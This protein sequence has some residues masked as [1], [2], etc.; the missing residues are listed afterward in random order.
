[1]SKYCDPQAESTILHWDGLPSLQKQKEHQRRQDRQV[2]DMDV[3]RSTTTQARIVGGSRRK[4]A[5]KKAK[6]V[7]RP[8][9]GVIGEIIAELILT[10]GCNVC[11]CSYQADTCIA[12][13]CA[14]AVHPEDLFVVSGDS[15]MIA[16]KSIPRLIYPLGKHREMTVIEKADLLRVLELPSDNHLLLAAI[17]A[18]NDYTSGMPYY[19]LSRSCDIIRS[20]DLPLNDIESFRQYVQEYLVRVQREIF[21]RKRTRKNRRRMET[22]LA[23]GVEDF[24]HALR[25]F[26]EMT[27]DP[28]PNSDQ[29]PNG[30]PDMATSQMDLDL[31]LSKAL[32]DMP[33]PMEIDGAPLELTP[34]PSP[35]QPSSTSALQDTTPHE[36]VVSVLYQLELD[37]IIRDTALPKQLQPPTLQQPA[38]NPKRRRHRRSK[39]Q[40]SKQRKKN[41]KKYATRKKWRQSKYRS[42]NDSNPRYS[43]H[44]VEDPSTASP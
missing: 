24:E 2:K 31:E 8:P 38:L 16:F 22:Q 35:N 12:R 1:M 23:V 14:Q 21:A 40:K 13:R 26:V 42:R 5:Y 27:E 4:A 28:E 7:Y 20:M 36:L 17:V 18:G 10:Y 43:A 32:D 44:R 6:N 41:S 15:D 33:T 25:A 29:E 11:F 37:K 30:D 34:A 3:L 39:T 9:L 19:G